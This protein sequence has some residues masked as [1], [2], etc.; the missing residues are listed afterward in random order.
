MSS[1]TPAVLLIDPDSRY[2]YD[3]AEALLAGS[4]DQLAHLRFTIILVARWEPSSSVTPRRRKE[5]R[6]ELTRLR[7][8]SLGMVDELAMAYGVHQALMTRNYV[9]RTVC[10]PKC[11]LPPASPTRHATLF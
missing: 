3:D 10:I 4:T 11:M 1:L 8:L 5:L 9:E 6:A 2:A 7:C